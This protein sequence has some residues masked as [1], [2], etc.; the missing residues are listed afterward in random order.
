[1]SGLHGRIAEA[2]AAYHR[3]HSTV[4]EHTQLVEHGAAADAV[5]ALFDMEA[6]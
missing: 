6:S 4:C 3:Q 5:M 2:L 1:M